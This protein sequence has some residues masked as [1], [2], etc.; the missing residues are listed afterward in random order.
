M[1]ALYLADLAE[2]FDPVAGM[3]SDGTL[4][5]YEDLRSAQPQDDPAQKPIYERG[6]KEMWLHKEAERMLLLTEARALASALILRAAIRPVPGKKDLSHLLPDLSKWPDVDK[7]VPDPVLRDQIKNGSVDLEAV[8]LD[9]KKGQILRGYT[10]GDFKEYE[11]ILRE[12]SSADRLR[13]SEKFWPRIVYK[14]E[15]ATKQEYELLEHQL[16]LD[17]EQVKERIKRGES[18]GLSYRQKT[19]IRWIS[20]ENGKYYEWTESPQ[21]AR[22]VVDQRVWEGSG[23]GRTALKF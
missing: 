20:S 1:S 11:R 4:I 2:G 17:D 18:S 7:L 9:N 3:K 23:P 6:E 5:R 21:G 13:L 19:G 10:T 22:R 12:E 14:E 15:I 8:V 16:K